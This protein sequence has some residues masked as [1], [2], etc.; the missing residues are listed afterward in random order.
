MT[1]TQETVRVSGMNDAACSV[2]VAT[3]NRPVRA[4]SKPATREG[5]RLKRR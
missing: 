4:T 5:L 1:E 3:Q 2:S